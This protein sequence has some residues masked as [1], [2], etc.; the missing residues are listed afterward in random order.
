M[1]RVG[2]P[3][4]LDLYSKVS[5]EVFNMADVD[6]SGKIN[7]NE[8]VAAIFSQQVDAEAKERALTAAFNDLAGGGSGHPAGGGRRGIGN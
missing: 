1:V 8:F 4:R 2:P 7:F 6:G 3:L 5:Q